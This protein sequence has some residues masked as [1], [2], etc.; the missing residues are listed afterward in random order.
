MLPFEQPVNRVVDLFTGEPVT[1]EKVPEGIL[2]TCRETE[3]EPI[4]QVFRLY[5]R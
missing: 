4:A 1:F 2:V 5:V 3:E